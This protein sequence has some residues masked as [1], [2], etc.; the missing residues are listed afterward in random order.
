MHT[1]KMIV[2]SSI[3]WFSK[4]DILIN[5]TNVY[6]RRIIRLLIPDSRKKIYLYAMPEEHFAR[7]HN[8]DLEMILHMQKCY[9]E[10]KNYQLII[11]T[12][13]ESSFVNKKILIL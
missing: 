9:G 10:Y 6:L 13:I 11:P 7:K 2:V 4:N 5:Y 8:E 12:N 3:R 1:I